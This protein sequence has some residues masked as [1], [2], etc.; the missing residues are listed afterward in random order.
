[1][2]QQPHVFSNRHMYRV[3][4]AVEGVWALYW[5]SEIKWTYIRLEGSCQVCFCQPSDQQ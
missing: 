2:P 4:H 5:G 3:C 1:M